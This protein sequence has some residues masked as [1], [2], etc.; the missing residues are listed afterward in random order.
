M[1]GTWVKAAM[2]WLQG[3]GA[4]LA[5]V[6]LTY[7]LDAFQAIHIDM[8]TTDGIAL[9]VV[10]TL[11]T[12]ALGWLMNKLGPANEGEPEPPV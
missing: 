3:I 12:K 7:L 4:G 6:V 2:K 11:A 8:T 5:T 1:L 9:V 10:V